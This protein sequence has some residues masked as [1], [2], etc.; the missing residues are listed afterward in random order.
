[1]AP[2]FLSLLLRLELKE[3][4]MEQEAISPLMG[5]KILYVHASCKILRM[6]K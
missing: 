6:L 3:S 2:E 5:R 4:R 1:M